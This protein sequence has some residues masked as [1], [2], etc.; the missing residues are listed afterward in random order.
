MVIIFKFHHSFCICSHNC[1]HY[2]TVKRLLFFLM[3]L[4]MYLYK[5]GPMD[6]HCILWVI[7]CT[8]NIYFEAE[9]VPDW[10]SSSR[11]FILLTCPHILFAHLYFLI[12]KD[13]PTS[14]CTFSAPHLKSAISSKNPDSF[15]WWIV[16]RN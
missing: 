16:F 2:T 15:Q 11:L 7:I 8:I 13:V 14:S 4:L 3:Y 9:I 1:F 10:V 6:S 5:Y 12:Q